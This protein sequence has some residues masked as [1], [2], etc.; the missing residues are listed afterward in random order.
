ML[1]LARD[2]SI[3]LNCV[4]ATEGNKEHLYRIDYCEKVLKYD[5]G[6]FISMTV[7]QHIYGRFIRTTRKY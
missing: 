1:I 4:Q 7:T 3:V 6:C 5:P 2:V